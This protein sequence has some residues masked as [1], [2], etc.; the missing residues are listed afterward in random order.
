MNAAVRADCLSDCMYDND[1]LQAAV[2]YAPDEADAAALEALLHSG[3]LQTHYQPANSSSCRA[4]DSMPRD[5]AELG[6]VTVC[7]TAA[8]FA[9]PVA[10]DEAAQRP[11]NRQLA[12]LLPWLAPQH[13]AAAAPAGCDAPLSP[14]RDGVRSLGGAGSGGDPGSPPQSPLARRKVN[15]GLTAVPTFLLCRKHDSL[16]GQLHAELTVGCG[17]GA[18]GISTFMRTLSKP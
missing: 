4:G 5:A 13:T 9:Q 15:S 7:L 17:C 8:V 10:A 14:T 12:A 1:L 6:S 2:V 16:L 18:A 3:H 11:W